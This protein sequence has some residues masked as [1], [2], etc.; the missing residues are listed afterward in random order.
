MAWRDSRKNRGKLLLFVSSIILGIAAL[1]AIHSFGENLE[2]DIARQAKTLLGADLTLE[3]R[4]D[5]A[6][7]PVSL[8][9]LDTA[10]EVEFVSM[11]SFPGSGGSRLTQVHALRGDY[12]F[13]GRLETEPREAPLVYQQ[14]RQALVDR[15]LALQYDVKVG[16]TVRVGRVNFAVAGL[17]DNAPGGTNL[18]SA[19]APPVYIP[20]QYLDATGLIRPGSRVEYK[21]HYRL[22]ENADVE[23]WAEENEEALRARQLDSDTPDEEQGRAGRSF[24]NLNDFLGLVAFVAL[25][26]GCVG[27]ASSV[28]LYI[29]D[30]VGTVAIMRCLGA[31][32]R[33]AFVVFLLQIFVMGLLGALAGAL[34][35]LGLQQFLPAVL[36]DFLP[37]E[38]STRLSPVSLAIGL[39][40]GLLMAMLFSL[41]PLLAIRKTSPLLAIRQS[42][43][44]RS[45][46][47]DPL[48]V[49]VYGL[50]VL[51]ILGFAW[52]QLGEFQEAAFF[53]LGLVVALGILLLV[54][55]GIMWGVRRWFPV[56][57]G[58]VWRQ[59]LANLY[60]PQNQTMVLLATIGLGTA[61]V[62]TVFYVQGM[63]LQQVELTGQGE[64][65]NL[66]LY[67]IQDDQID[68]VRQLLRERD[69][70]VMQTDP[71]V[72]MRLT[73]INGLD[74]ETVAEDS[75]SRLRDWSFRREY[76]VTY[77]AEPG[78]TETIVAGSWQG[79][80]RPG[81]A[82]PISMEEGFAERAGLELGD[83]L[84]F[85]VQGLPVEAE[86][87]SLRQ[88]TWNR[89]SS[90]FFVVFPTGV[91]E[92]APQFHVLMT[93]VPDTEASA[94]FQQAVLAE[95]P[96]VSIV[97]LG[98]IL[99]TVE[100]LL[101]KVAFV[102]RFMAFFSILTGLLVLI[103]SVILSRFQRLQEAVLLRTLGSSRKQLLVITL[104]EYFIL[105]SLATLTGIL[106]ALG[107]TWALAYFTFDMIFE[108]PLLPV[109]GIYGAIT[110][111]TILIGFLNSQGV[112]HR[113]PLEILRTAE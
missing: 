99:N 87:S 88:V 101:E 44:E 53:T 61:L 51:T 60:R 81:E 29:R 65:P 10:R 98:L 35:G 40:T 82:V 47:R 16:D 84:V 77:R 106:L 3:T 8:P 73:R 91:L 46:V 111:L 54:S 1:V 100:A 50:V 19:V 31:S 66:L 93:R 79:E 33:Q 94:R 104:F 11:V 59:S 37:V 102:I 22:A 2:D 56:S 64:R 45:S 5:T 38:V 23:R 63:L 70:Q 28:H 97:N 39:G 107:A 108:P 112:I 83:R 58:Y 12:P 26:L 48:V 110:G 25:L 18:S 105:G 96:T 30:K 80:A 42:A 103:S 52:L 74:R 113:P 57:W 92:D 109:L 72:N 14:G 4:S 62:S 85:D 24:D 41:P 7:F 34:V 55:R 20:L 13:Y 36:A 27:V 75:T 17:L 69:L 86:I 95:F 49:G 78:P 76:R 15:S 68:S 9:V 32:G 89:I 43:G 90:N 71:V 67:D 6:Y 21:T